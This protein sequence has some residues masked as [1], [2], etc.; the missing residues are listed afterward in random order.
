MAPVISHVNPCEGLPLSLEAQSFVGHEVRHQGV[1]QTWN[2]GHRFHLQSLRI[3][4]VIDLKLKRAKGSFFFVVLSL[5]RW[6]SELVELPWDLVVLVVSCVAPKWPM[7]HPS[8]RRRTW[9]D[10]SGSQ[11]PMA[12]PRTSRTRQNW[13]LRELSRKPLKYEAF[14]KPGQSR[15]VFAHGP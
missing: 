14:R 2:E 8:C 15:K 11:V 1:V 13:D 9:R 12:G 3:D 7:C 4:E 10:P 6:R 5:F